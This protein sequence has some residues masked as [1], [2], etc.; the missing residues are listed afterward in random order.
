VASNFVLEFE[1]PII[2][3]EQKV[4][5]MRSLPNAQEIESQILELEANIEELR[6]NVY[7]HLTRW[8]RVQIARH[9]ER[10]YTL[11]YISFTFS[12][13][14]EL[15]GDRGYRDDPAIVGGLARLD[16]MPVM[17]IGHQKGRDTKSNLHRNFGMP[18]P[19]GYRKAKRLMLLAEKFNVPVICLLDTPGA[20]PGI[21][22][23]ERGQAQAI[24]DNLLVMSGLRTPIIICIIGEGASGGALGIGIGDR[25]LMLENAWYSV[26]APESCSS[27]LWRSW[28]FKEQ[29][30]EALKLTA[31]D[32]QQFGIIDRIVPEPTGGA[33]RAPIDMFET[34]KNIFV[35][36][37][38][39]LMSKDLETLVHERRE[40]FAGMGVWTES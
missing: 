12:D 27:I 37:L 39:K 32:L 24:A 29:A 17:V 19:E 30:A 40:K 11:D 23:E 38:N 3:L 1:K 16:G 5:E 31:P 35:E 13:F 14:V 26:I 15:H 20:F 10:P 4:S 21:E 28:D 6:S 2:E 7:A 22:A 25:V 34:L 9:P 36:E 33:H 18:N 8:Q